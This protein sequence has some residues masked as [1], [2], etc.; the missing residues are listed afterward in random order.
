M[1]ID[2]FLSVRDCV[3]DSEDLLAL[4]NLAQKS[5]ATRKTL[6]YRVISLSKKH[7]QHPSFL[8]VLSKAQELVPGDAVYREGW[9]IVYDTR[10]EGVPLHADRGY[11][12]I[13]TWLTPDECI[14]PDANGLIVW[15]I[16]VPDDWKFHEYNNS[17]KYNENLE[18]LID[19]VK[20]TKIEHAFNRTIIFRSKLLHRTD[21]VH[22]RAGNDSRR[23]NLTLMYDRRN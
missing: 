8:R 23:V 6:S 15:N 10:C 16:S 19:G 7:K 20:Y 18:R 9:F 5:R 4:R 13:N 12:T 1:S 22:T 17:N 2:P 11:M 3:F 14:L 21:H